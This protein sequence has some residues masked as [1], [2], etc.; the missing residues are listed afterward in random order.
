MKVSAGQKQENCRN[1]R[2][3][4]D[5][6][7]KQYK[8]FPTTQEFEEK[9]NMSESTVRRYKK[10]IL[11]ENKEI[12][13]EKY[14]DQLIIRVDDLINTLDDNIKTL[15]AMKKP[16]HNPND[17]ISIINTIEEKKLNI[18]RLMR[19]SPMYFGILENDDNNDNESDEQEHIHRETFTKEKVTDGFQ[20]LFN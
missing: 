5:D 17:T 12:L 19:D 7:I 14:Q 1:M 16:T 18:M 8:R 6:Y 20:T 10:F 4:I 3:M 15:E 11:D 13:N 9:L 2:G